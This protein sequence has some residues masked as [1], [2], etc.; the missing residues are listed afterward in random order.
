MDLEYELSNI[1]TKNGAM[2]EFT[3]PIEYSY[4]LGLATN[5]CRYFYLYIH[6]SEHV[7]NKKRPTT[8]ANNDNQD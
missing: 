5:Y 6:A 1:C 7:K 3:L 8:V 4:L 2:F